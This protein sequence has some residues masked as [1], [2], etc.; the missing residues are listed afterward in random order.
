[1]RH[2]SSN[3][4]GVWWGCK[5]CFPYRRFH[6][7][8][9]RCNNSPAQYAIIAMRNNP[10]DLSQGLKRGGSIINTASFGRCPSI[11]KDRMDRNNRLQKLLVWGLQPLSSHTRRQK[12]LFLR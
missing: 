2:L 1:M 12:V 4:K 3:V 6:G 7:Y 11:A 5:V 10:E 9:R 8:A